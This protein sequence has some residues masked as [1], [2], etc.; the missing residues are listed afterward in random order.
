L[1]PLGALQQLIHGRSLTGFYDD[2]EGGIS[3]DFLA[4]VLP[5][6]QGV[7]DAEIGYDAALRVNNDNVMVIARPIEAGVMSQFLPSFHFD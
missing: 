4:E 5:A 2:T 7:R 1:L 3:G 6:S